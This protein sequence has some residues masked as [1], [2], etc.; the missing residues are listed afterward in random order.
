[1]EDTDIEIGLKE[2]LGM[3][4]GFVLIVSGIASLY[5]LIWGAWPVFHW[6]AT[7]FVTVII[8]LAVG[9]ITIND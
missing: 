3:V 8:L 7:V 4:C 9:V 2:V 5:S 1:M 6:S